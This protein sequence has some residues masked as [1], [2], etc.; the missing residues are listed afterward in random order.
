M[1]MYIKRKLATIYSR[2]KIWRKNKHKKFYHKQ[3]KFY[4]KQ[5][6]FHHKQKKFYRK[7]KKFGEVASIELDKVYSNRK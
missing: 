2:L 1:Y 5:T 3:K 4:H 7:Q 6:K